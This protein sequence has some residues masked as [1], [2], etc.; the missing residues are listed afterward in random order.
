MIL[1]SSS[2]AQNGLNH[3]LYVQARPGS[4][5]KARWPLNRAW[6]PAD[7]VSK[8]RRLS[9]PG[10]DRRMDV[11][12]N[13]LTPGGA[14]RLAL[15]LGTSYQATVNHLGDLRL[16]ASSSVKDALGARTAAPDLRRDVWQIDPARDP[17]PVRAAAGDLLVVDLEETPSVVTS[18]LSRCQV[19]SRS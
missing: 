15:E 12:P 19:A 5:V 7:F 4:M 17:A 9:R 3:Q 13:Q 6:G 1:I 14:Y 10:H 18:G 2:H 11:R 8:S 16:I